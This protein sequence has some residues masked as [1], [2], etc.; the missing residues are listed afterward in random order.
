MNERSTIQ[1]FVRGARWAVLGLGFV[2]STAAFAD[3]P[4]ESLGVPTLDQAPGLVNPAPSCALPPVALP[5]RERPIDLTDIRLRWPVDNRLITSDFGKRMDPVA[6]TFKK[7][8]RGVDIR[9]DTGTPVFSSADGIVTYAK[10]HGRGGLTIKIE[11]GGEMT[12]RY[13]HLNRALVKPGDRVRAG[14]KIALSGA[15]GRVTGP[16]LHFEVWTGKKARNPLSAAFALPEDPFLGPST[17]A[18]DP[19][20]VS[21]SLQF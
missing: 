13:A 5:P 21:S 8:H 2:L 19:K 17:T 10:R 16:H 6:G 4:F 9:C 7:N 20:K 1:G 15:S 18:Y 12:T 14:Q 3:D 11:H